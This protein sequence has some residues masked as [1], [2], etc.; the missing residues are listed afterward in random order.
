MK[1][2]K[3]G[4]D[5]IQERAMKENGFATGLASQITLHTL[6]KEK[7]QYKVVCDINPLLNPFSFPRAHF[8]KVPKTFR[9]QKA[10]RKTPTHLFCKAGLFVCCKGNKHWNNCKFPCLET[11]SFWRYKENYVSRNSPKKFRDFLETGPSSL[12]SNYNQISHFWDLKEKI[13]FSKQ[14]N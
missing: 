10:S 7:S 3:T 1:E 12:I 4:N 9:A 5:F 2:W 6:F 13:N 11:P 14:K 8:S